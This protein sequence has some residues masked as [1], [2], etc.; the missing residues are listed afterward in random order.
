[1]LLQKITS[2]FLGLWLIGTCASCASFA[3]RLA[4]LSAADSL[5][6]AIVDQVLWTRIYGEGNETAPPILRVPVDGKRS[7]IGSDALTLQ[8]DMRTGHMPNY[9][10]QL[11]HCDRNWTPTENIFV[12]DPMRMQSSDFTIERSPLATSHYD[13]TVTI[14]FPSNSSNLK[15]QYSGNYIARVIDFFDNG[16][17]ITEARFFAVE[18]SA[19]VQVGLYSDFYES[20]QTEVLQHGLRAQV[21]A[22]LK[23]NLFG[24]QINAIHLY[25]RGMWMRPMVA[26]DHSRS[27]ANKPGEVWPRWTSL[28]GGRTTAEFRNIPAGNEHRLLDLTDLTLYPTTGG[29]ITTPLADLPRNSFVYLDN[30]GT[31]VDRFVPAIDDDYVYFE[32]RLDLAGQRVT[33]DLAVVGTFNNWQPTREWRLFYDERTGFYIARG[34]VKRA[35]HEYEYVAGTWDEDLGRLR[36]PDATLLEGNVRSAGHTYLAFIYYH[37]SSAG[38]YD[39]IIGVGAGSSGI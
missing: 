25:Q 34:W 10:L 12:Q 28:F 22:Q 33:E 23:Q 29:I 35:L 2:L 7:E 3:Q 16:K 27:E 9:T 37:E 39:R 20:A 4:E 24:S 13:Y 14:T 11:V 36:D 26:D 15:I 5:Q 17:V 19:E 38:G 32:F 30:D 8:F 31:A 1:M 18:P 6:G 21:D